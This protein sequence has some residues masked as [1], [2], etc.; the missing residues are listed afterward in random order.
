MG[1]G[2]L[3]QKPREAGG[4]GRALSYGS[5]P[6]AVGEPCEDP[7]CSAGLLLRSRWSQSRGHQAPALQTEQATQDPVDRQSGSSPATN[8]E[9]NLKGPSRGS[10]YPRC[11]D[12]EDNPVSR[13]PL[14]L[15]GFGEFRQD[16]GKGPQDPLCLGLAAMMSPFPSSFLDK[17]NMNGG[18][19]TLNLQIRQPPTPKRLQT[20]NTHMDCRPP[21][22][23]PGWSSHFLHGI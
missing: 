17:W 18:F 23:C 1:V 12:L 13:S 16:Y 5:K 21:Q 20:P 15:L 7:E 8:R 6:R 9:N 22:P 11:V 2:L 14:E 4:K 3:C 19:R 10:P